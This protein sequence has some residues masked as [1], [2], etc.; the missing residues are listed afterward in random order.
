MNFYREIAHFW[1]WENHENSMI[2][3][4]KRRKKGVKARRQECIEPRTCCFVGVLKA[5]RRRNGSCWF[6]ERE[7]ERER[8]EE[9][10]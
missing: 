6:R 7:R 8:K 1:R 5:R 10:Y 2:G 3:I 9:E 4:S